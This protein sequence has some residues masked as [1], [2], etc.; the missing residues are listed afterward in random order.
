MSHLK[1]IEL[2]QILDGTLPLLRRP[3]ANLH[4]KSCKECQARLDKLRK[5]NE[6]LKKL[7]GFMQRLDDAD[8]QSMEATS[9]R[10]TTIFGKSDSDN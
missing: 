8:S 4:L 6:E 3:F 2:E 1:D 9:S 7:F 10:I 5:D